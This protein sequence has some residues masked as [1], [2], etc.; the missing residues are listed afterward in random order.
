MNHSNI[1]YIYVHLLVDAG[2]IYPQVDVTRASTFT[3]GELLSRVANLMCSHK[4]PTRRQVGDVANG[5]VWQD[6]G[7]SVGDNLARK[8]L[9]SYP[10][11]QLCF[12]KLYII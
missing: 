10:S 5:M 11:Y 2:V 3:L 1:K 4:A 12:L 6:G 9:F 7:V 8:A